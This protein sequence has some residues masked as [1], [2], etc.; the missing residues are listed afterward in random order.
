MFDVVVAWRVE[1]SAQEG[2]LAIKLRALA[3]YDA[4]PENDLD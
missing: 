2:D 3:A 4:A 1:R